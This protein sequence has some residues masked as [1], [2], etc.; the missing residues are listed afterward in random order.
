MTEKDGGRAELEARVR[1]LERRAE[2]AEIEAAAAALKRDDYAKAVNQWTGRYYEMEAKYVEIMKERD[3]LRR[4]LDER[5][6]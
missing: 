1:E 2:R 4:R 5:D 6:A 3:E